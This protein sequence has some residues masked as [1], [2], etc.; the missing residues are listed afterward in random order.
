[1]TRIMV[2]QVQRVRR[3]R[4]LPERLRDRRRPAGAARSAEPHAAVARR[5][6]HSGARPAGRRAFPAAR[7]RDDPA[8]RA[9]RLH[10]E[11][12]AREL[13]RSP[14]REIHG[15]EESGSKPDPHVGPIQSDTFSF[16]LSRS[17]SRIALVSI[18]RAPR[19]ASSSASFAVCTSYTT[20]RHG[21][22]HSFDEV[23][24]NSW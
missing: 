19:A 11:F 21:P 5:S 17:K 24:V 20:Q 8:R 18:S 22:R 7:D 16:L 6:D 4:R 1:M 13:G 15:A 9:L 2:E 14:G 3:P 12:R 10:G 23:S